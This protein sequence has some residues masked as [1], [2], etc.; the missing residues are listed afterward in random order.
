MIII[1]TAYHLLSREELACPISCI[2]SMLEKSEATFL[3]QE[4]VTFDLEED[5]NGY[6]TYNN[7]HLFI[8]PEEDVNP[9][10][11]WYTCDQGLVL[12]SEKDRLIYL[13]DIPSFFKKRGI[14]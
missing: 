9:W 14:L 5:E 3:I 6:I 2:L 8:E 13:E 11:Y 1:N 7:R 4:S 12:G 10:F